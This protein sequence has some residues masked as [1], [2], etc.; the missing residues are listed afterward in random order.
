MEVIGI[1]GG[2]ALIAAVVIAGGMWLMGFW[3]SRGVP[4]EPDKK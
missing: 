2:V 4:R 1:I 3:E